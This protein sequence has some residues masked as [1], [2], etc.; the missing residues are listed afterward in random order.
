MKK[1][2]IIISIIALIRF[3]IAYCIIQL[4]I[5]LIVS[6][7]D[8]PFIFQVLFFIFSI[9]TLCPYVEAIPSTI[10]HFSLSENI[11]IFYL[12]L[13]SIAYAI[14][15]FFVV[16]GLTALFRFLLRSKV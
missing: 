16:Y 6:G 2:I 3:V 13:D 11:S 15:S 9:I 7:S 8:L 1:A 4:F 5:G 12:A 10:L 14:F